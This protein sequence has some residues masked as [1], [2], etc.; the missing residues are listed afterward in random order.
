M[1]KFVPVD[2]DGN[3][4]VNSEDTPTTPTSE[5]S[6]DQNTDRPKKKAHEKSGR[7]GFEGRGGKRGGKF[8]GPAR[9]GKPQKQ[10]TTTPNKSKRY[11][12]QRHNN[13]ADDKNSQQYQQYYQDANGYPYAYPNNS[14]Q[15]LI[16]VPIESYYAMT[17]QEGYYVQSTPVY[18]P[19]SDA[20]QPYPY[21]PSS[22]FYPQY[23][24]NGDNNGKPRARLN[25]NAKAFVPSFGYTPTAPSTQQQ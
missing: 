25:P 2:K 22:E 15:P 13:E 10:N 21:V 3:Q 5:Q 20:Y 12:Q 24:A 7:G 1:K 23:P 14:S 17:G 9:E 6:G 18:Y 11:S 8:S 4:V 16:A 19:Q